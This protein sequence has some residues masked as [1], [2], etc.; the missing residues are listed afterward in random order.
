MS[1]AAAAGGCKRNAGGDL[2]VNPFCQQSTKHFFCLIALHTLLASAH[3]PE[4]LTAHPRT[5]AT[6]CTI[7]CLS[8]LTHLVTIGKR[9]IKDKEMIHN[10]SNSDGISV[11]RPKL[12]PEER[13]S[14]PC[15]MPSVEVGNTSS[16]NLENY[17]LV[18]SQENCW[19]V[20]VG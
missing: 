3:C 8:V 20:Q 13:N 2:P 7:S 18:F 16:P 9:G 11:H 6:P 14:I 1:L 12:V 17:G 5:Q 15:K 19:I 10:I 4:M